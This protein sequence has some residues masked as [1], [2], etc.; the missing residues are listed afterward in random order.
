MK[1][2]KYLLICDRRNNLIYGECIEW[3]LSKFDRDNIDIISGK[4]KKKYKYYIMSINEEIHT[5]NNQ[6]ITFSLGDEKI[7]FTFSES[8]QDTIY[9]SDD[10]ELYNPLI[11]HCTDINIY[12]NDK[13]SELLNLEWLKENKS[14]ID[15]V[16]KRFNINLE[17]NQELI[18]SF[19]VYNPI[20]LLIKIRF[21]DKPRKNEDKL[22][23]SLQVSI[24]DEFDLYKDTCAKINIWDKDDIIQTEF[25]KTSEKI[26]DFI[27][28]EYPHKIELIIMDKDRKIYKSKHGFVRSINFDVNIIAGSVRLENGKTKSLIHNTKLSVGS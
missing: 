2:Y 20:R 24:L 22:P 18:G 8:F 15:D 26:F 23:K 28:K 3:E 16:E 7:L 10:E 12:L 9:L 1:K 19:S 25:F 14:L 5:V 17:K 27:A 6:N 4:L 13:K 11:D 21:T